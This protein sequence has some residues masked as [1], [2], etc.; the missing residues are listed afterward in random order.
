[1]SVFV[2]EEKCVGCSLCTR[3]C[4][5]GGIAVEGGKAKILPACTG[6][7]SCVSACKFGALE[8]D[9]KDTGK[10]DL[11]A[12][13]DIW[14]FA[15]QREGELHP[16]VIELLGEGRKLAS[17][18]GCRLCAILCGDK[19]DKLVSQLGAYGADVVYVAD[20]PELAIY[21][22]DGYAKILAAAINEY[23]P[24]VVLYGATYIGRDLAPRIA[25]EVDTGLTA[26]CTVLAVDPETKELLQTRPAFGGNL[27][28]TIITPNHRPQMATVRRGVMQKAEYDEARK[29][30][31]VSL[32]AD[33][34]AGEIRTKI[35]EVVK[36][37]TDTVSL[38][39]AEIIVSGGAGL[40]SADGFDLIGQ[41]AHKLGA[42]V[43]ASR[44]AVDSGW[45][46]ASYQVGQTGT[47]VK[48]KIYIACGISG[49]I[50][51]LAGMQTS[52]TIIAINKNPD[53]P[54]FKVAD[55]GLVGDLYQ[56]IPALMELW[57]EKN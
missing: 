17:A 49:A 11:S 28:A 34:A 8:S 9:A 23:K 37:V 42:A 21:N 57:P 15:E 26:D 3:S 25:V 24:E 38:A 56:V 36:N 51:H 50:Q 54:I 7:G 18:L 13:K 5:Y 43:G 12:Y 16:V 33:F 45:I 44:A 20:A 27:M 40:G 29:A 46:D 6:C 1:M 22:T 35:L 4:P 19:T 41:F 55:Y 53:A 30:Q 2:N 39:D 10:K 47:T 32:P 48:P 31:V 14:V 52:D